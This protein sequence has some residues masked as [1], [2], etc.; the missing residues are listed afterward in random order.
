MSGAPEAR[1][2]PWFP[3]EKEPKIAT[4]DT[5]LIIESAC[6]GWQEGGARFPAVPRTI[7]EQAREIAASVKAGAIAVH[8]HPRDPQ[9]G[10]MVMSTKLL[11]EI[12]DRVFDAVGDCVTLPHSWW[13]VA[14]GE[15][16]YIS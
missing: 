9:T 13:P 8:I 5:P 6:P 16:D 14:G 3:I 2:V 10:K 12:M 11:K 4:L 7:K 15:I 1:T